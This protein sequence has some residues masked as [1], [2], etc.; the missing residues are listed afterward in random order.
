MSKDKADQELP[1]YFWEYRKNPWF[2]AYAPGQERSLPDDSTVH[3]GMAT[4]ILHHNDDCGNDIFAPTRFVS[5]D[6][7]TSF[8]TQ[9]IPVS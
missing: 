6:T 8:F 2:L 3:Q 9:A 1:P 4:A 5:V 7:N